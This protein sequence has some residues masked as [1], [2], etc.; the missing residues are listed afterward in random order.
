MS[1][2]NETFHTICKELLPSW[3]ENTFTV[4]YNYGPT[5]LLYHLSTFGLRLQNNEGA[6]MFVELFRIHLPLALQK[7][8]VYI[9]KKGY[10]LRMLNTP[11]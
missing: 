10:F 9:V 6:S 1:T 5:K 8:V 2:L 7:Y 4:S 11:K 3:D